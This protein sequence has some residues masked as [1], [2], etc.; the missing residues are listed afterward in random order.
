MVKLGYI[1]IL[2]FIYSTNNFNFHN[3]KFDYIYTTLL[4]WFLK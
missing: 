3:I 4:N 2:L 1:T